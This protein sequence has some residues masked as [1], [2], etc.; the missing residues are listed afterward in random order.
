MNRSIDRSEKESGRKREREIGERE[1]VRKLNFN[2][3]QDLS[4]RNIRYLIK[5]AEY[6]SI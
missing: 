3:D 2:T 6:G 5:G 4:R 1:R